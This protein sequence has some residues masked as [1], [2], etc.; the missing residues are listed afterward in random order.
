M[1]QI[2]RRMAETLNYA[3]RNT[4]Y[5]IRESI[6]ELLRTKLSKNYT[7]QT[8]FKPNF[9][10]AKMNINL[11]LT[12]GYRKKDDFAVRKNKPNFRNAKK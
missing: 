2:R 4:T 10:K 7:K 9:K 3:I 12:K 5:D 8:Q 11:T 1:S 6:Y